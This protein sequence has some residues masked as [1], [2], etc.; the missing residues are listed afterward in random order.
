MLF[1]FVRPQANL[2]QL[3]GVAIAMRLARPSHHLKYL[4]SVTLDKV[5]TTEKFKTGFS[6]LAKELI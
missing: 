3:K 4:A 2:G 1:Y 6:F 5:V